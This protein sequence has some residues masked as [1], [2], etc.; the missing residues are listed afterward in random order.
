MFA[1]GVR[2]VKHQLRPKLSEVRTITLDDVSKAK[3]QYSIQQHIKP[4]FPCVIFQ[5]CTYVERK[6]PSSPVP[7]FAQM[8]DLHLSKFRGQPE[9][10]DELVRLCGFLKSN[11]RP[12]AA[13]VS[14]DL[15]DAK[16]YSLFG[17]EQYVE[18][19]RDYNGVISRCDPDFAWLDI[20]GNHDVFDVDGDDDKRNMFRQYSKQGPKHPRTYLESVNTPDGKS[21]CFLGVDATPTPGLKR[22]FNFFGLLTKE[23]VFL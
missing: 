1:N 6:W 21:V 4:T 16:D 22:L 13:V 23:E 3:R 15:T 11:V 8:S 17:S 5:T 7:R 10:A 18:E 12:S 9:R 14:G 19:W 20:R 2:S